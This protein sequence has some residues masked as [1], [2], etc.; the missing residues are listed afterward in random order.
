LG[1]CTP[2]LRFPPLPAPPPP[3]ALDAIAV[4]QSQGMVHRDLQAQNVL[5]RKTTP[6]QV[7]VMDFC[8]INWKGVPHVFNAAG[9]KLGR[10]TRTPDW[11]VLFVFCCCKAVWAE[12]TRLC[13]SS[14]LW[15][16]C[17]VLYNE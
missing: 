6:P 16:Q 12:C 10:F 7:V 2:D 11:C 15:L 13:V 9:R 8:W 5:V 4:M 3:Q 14:F 1:S 17:I